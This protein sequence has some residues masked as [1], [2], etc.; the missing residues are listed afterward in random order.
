MKLVNL[1]KR[2][3]RVFGVGFYILGATYT[4]CVKPTEALDG[5]G[6]P[7][8]STCGAATIPVT[9]FYGVSGY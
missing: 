5:I 6:L 3:E 8:P 1:R 2:L 7:G 4:F 9:D